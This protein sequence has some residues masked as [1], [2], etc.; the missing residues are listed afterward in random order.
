MC[1]WMILLARDVDEELRSPSRLGQHQVGIQRTIIRFV[2]IFFT[3]GFE[4][5]S[6]QNKD[7]T[8]GICFF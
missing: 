5:R 7:Y 4:P 2:G 6:G 1:R 3:R 8:T